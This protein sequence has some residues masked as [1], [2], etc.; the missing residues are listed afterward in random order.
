MQPAGDNGVTT[1]MLPNGA[2]VSVQELHVYRV[3]QKLLSTVTHTDFPLL[4]NSSVS[5]MYTIMTDA[6]EEP[7]HCPV[8]YLDTAPEKTSSSSLHRLPPP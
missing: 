2:R 8:G 1:V 6:V 3:Q 7:R 5:L 4:V